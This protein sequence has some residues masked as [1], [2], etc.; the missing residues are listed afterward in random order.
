M[1]CTLI[2]TR[3]AKSA[4]DTNVPSDHARPLNKRG[5]R[6]AP[7]IGAWLRDNGH[8]PDQVISSSSQRTRETWELMGLEAQATAFT[9][10]LYHANSDIMLQLLQQA[11]RPCVMM[12]GHNPGIAAFAHSI[13]KHPPDHSRFDDY[14]TGATLVARFKAE[15]WQDI[16]WSSAKVLDFCVP[17]ELLGE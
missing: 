9:E 7:A 17:R 15:R 5:R 11:E 13:V 1:T 14:P 2:L 16:S 12:I 10:R 6:S 4:W 3:H 8:L